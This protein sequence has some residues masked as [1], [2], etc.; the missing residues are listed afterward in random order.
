PHVIAQNMPAAGSR[1][2]AD[3]IAAGAPRDGTVI[4]T[5]AQSAPLDERLKHEGT[6]FRTVTFNWI[7]NPVVDNNVTIVWSDSG[8]VTIEDVLGRDGLIC[9]GSTVA[10]PSITFPRILNNML[11]ARIRV[12]P[13]YTTTGVSYA[14]A[15][16]R[17]EI[18][19]SGGNS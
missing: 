13:G 6:Q 2:A 17:G 11:G 18:N 19:C 15:M 10:T 16:E 4:G 9:G 5:I 8:Y 14:L 3:Y 12:V 7:G 1:K